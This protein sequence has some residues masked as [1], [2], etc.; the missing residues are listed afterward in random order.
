MHRKLYCSFADVGAG[1]PSGRRSSALRYAR[2]AVDVESKAHL[3][4]VCCR[5]VFP[6]NLY[7]FPAKGF[8]SVNP[9]DC[10]LLRPFV[11]IFCIYGMWVN[12]LYTGGGSV[13]KYQLVNTL[14]F[15]QLLNV[16]PKRTFTARD[17]VH[18]LPYQLIEELNAANSMRLR[19]HARVLREV[20]GSR[21]NKNKER[22]RALVDQIPCKGGESVRW[23]EDTL[24]F[25]MSQQ[26][27]MGKSTAISYVMR[28]P[29]SR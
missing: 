19:K 15:H 7:R 1:K 25:G 20:S 13:L 4:I 10:K 9:S 18:N 2:A 6:A 28:I 22:I 17:T 12:L 11:G 26:C 29:R 23:I 24:W 21:E 14:S 8:R 16:L 3:Q 27:G 5:Q